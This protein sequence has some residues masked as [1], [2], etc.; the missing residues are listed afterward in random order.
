MIIENQE[1]STLDDRIKQDIGELYSIL[2]KSVQLNDIKSVGGIS[3]AIDLSK[4]LF[5]EN[6]EP[7][8]DAYALSTIGLPGY[9]TGNREA[10]TV[11]VMLN[12]GI[13]AMENDNPLRTM[14]SIKDLEIDLDKGVDEFI[15]SY[16]EKNSKYGEHKSYKVDAFDLKQAVFLSAWIDTGV[17]I[18]KGFPELLKENTCK[19]DAVIKKEIDKLKKDATINVLTQKLQLELIPYASRKFDSHKTN[20]KVL[21]P[22]LETLL[23]EIFKAD[24]KYIIFCSNFFERLFKAYSKEKNKCF[25]IVIDEKNPASESES[26]EV[27]CTLVKITN[28]GQTK[29]AIIAHTF[30]NQSLTNAYDKMREYGLRCFECL[31]EYQQTHKS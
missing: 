1:I 28:N 29:P 23:H 6:G 15:N 10:K 20:L 21:M 4:D 7:K 8:D 22:Y 9:F 25:E 13:S 3:A 17:D 12:P 5:G 30:S 11:M 14:K 19:K 31:N 26:D 16:I 24:R 2:H 27:H 18:P